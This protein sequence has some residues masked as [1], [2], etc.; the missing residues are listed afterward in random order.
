[1]NN[2]AIF[3]SGEGTTAEAFI[4]SGATGKTNSQVVLVIC[5]NTGAGI[6]ERIKKLNKQFGLDIKTALINS[7]TNPAGRNENTLPGHQTL[8]EEKAILLMLQ[9]NNFE[10]IMLMGYLK[11]I[12][13]TL[14]DIYGWKNIYKSPYQA[15]MLNTHPGLLPE[16][17]GL[18]GRLIQSH[19]IDNKLPYAGQTLHVVAEKYDD[20]PIVAEHKIEVHK[21][22]TAD[23]LFER[24]RRVEKLNLPMDIDKFITNRQ[25]YI[26]AT[27]EKQ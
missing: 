2:I 21:D 16:T 17:K 22:D 3:A 23:S 24:I 20:G 14:V 27:E 25:N 8:E 6:F 10:L 26:K 18:Y 5:N 15:M 4:K 1:M 9:Q 13:P 7:K 12:G 11:H 19:V